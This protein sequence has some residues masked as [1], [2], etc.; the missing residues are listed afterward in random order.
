VLKKKGTVVRS[1]AQV[2]P[3]ERL[4]TRLAVGTVESTVEDSAQMSLFE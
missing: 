1:A 3:S 2:K 4:V